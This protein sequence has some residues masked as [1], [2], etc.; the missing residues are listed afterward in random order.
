MTQEEVPVPALWQSRGLHAPSKMGFVGDDTWLDL[1]P[2]AF[3]TAFP[4]PS[5]NTRDLNTVDNGC[6]QHLPYFLSKLRRHERRRPDSRHYEQQDH[7]NEHGNDNDDNDRFEV[8][9]VHFLGV[10]HVGHTYGPHN[11]HMDAKLRQMDTAL[12]D[13]LQTLDNDNDKDDDDDDSSCRV[14]FIFGDHG[15]TPDGNHGGGTEEE[16]NA[17]LFVHSSPACAAAGHRRRSQ[18][19]RRHRHSANGDTGSDGADGDHGNTIDDDDDVATSRDLMNLETL[20]RASDLVSPIHQSVFA[21]IRQIDIV[22]TISMLLGLPIPFANLGSVVPLLLPKSRHSMRQSAAALALNAAQVWRYLNIYS[23]TASTLPNLHVLEQDLQLAVKMYQQALKADRSDEKMDDE[24]LYLQAATLFKLFLHNALELGQRVWT[25]FDLVG[26]AGGVGVLA[27][28]LALFALPILQSWILLKGSS[29]VV[30]AHKMPMRTLTATTTI[31][32]SQYAEITLALVFVLFQCGALTFG[33]SYILEE[34]RSTMYCLSVLSMA[35]AIRLYTST[36]TT[37]TTST[38]MDKNATFL[39][40]GMLL[41]PMASRISQLVVSGHGMDPSIHVHGVHHAGVFLS[42]LAWLTVVRVFVVY[43]YQQ[44]HR[45]TKTTF[46]SILFHAVVDCLTLVA[47]AYSW[48]EKRHHRNGYLPCR[49]ALVL[50]FI[51]IPVSIVQAF[52]LRIQ[53]RCR[54]RL[55]TAAG[56]GEVPQSPKTDK[57][58]NAGVDQ[59]E[60]KQAAET[61]NDLLTILS[62]VLIAIMAVTGPSTAATLVLYTL[63]VIILF[64]LCSFPLTSSPTSQTTGRCRGTTVSPVVLAAL[65]KLVTR[66]V[67]FATNH[68]CAFSRLQ[69]SA[70]F[71]ATAEFYFA[72]GGISLFLNTFGWE[73]VGLAFC[74]VFGRVQQQQQQQQ[75]QQGSTTS[76]PSYSSSS[77]LWKVYGV[78]QLL[79]ALASCISVSVLRRHLMVWDIYAPHFV[80]VAIFTVLTGFA[81]L[82]A[83][84]LTTATMS[85]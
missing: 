26:M 37:T 69:Y 44:R 62:K 72:T 46:S 4:Y 27:C 14:A 22:P 25:R 45:Q 67:F 50:L 23:T 58:D 35:V 73:V 52:V 63:Q 7:D 68:A 11:Q 77:V 39:W 49:L 18:Q 51:G 29:S 65:W 64:H 3:D 78:Y 13:I 42:S 60:Q 55:M 81:H 31:P 34:E 21:A 41:L 40:I 8:V 24:D 28:G 1:F 38:T 54:Q 6:L 5:F 57:N 30:D 84:G 47:M 66:H 15:M 9:V 19:Q 53:Q 82:L 70:A 80:F 12:A 20:D 74:W 48:W 2:H 79:E 59:E 61:M 32:L 85:A 75:Q 76:S 33:N 43:R 36:A 83:I 56:I 10:D 16:I 17:A 71:I